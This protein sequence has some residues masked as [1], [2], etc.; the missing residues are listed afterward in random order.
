MPCA[1]CCAAQKKKR[2]YRGNS[3]AR[4]AEI[5]IA[6]NEAHLGKSGVEG[7]SGRQTGQGMGA[8]LPAGQMPVMDKSL[9][10]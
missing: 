10:A 3:S 9:V 2:C 5:I 6:V 8:G 1:M 4:Y 7:S